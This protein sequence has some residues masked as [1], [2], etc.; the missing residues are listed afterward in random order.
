[1]EC[2]SG[3]HSVVWH[4][5]RLVGGQAT[6]SCLFWGLNRILTAHRNRQGSDLARPNLHD[7]RGTLGIDCVKSTK[8]AGRGTTE[9]GSFAC[10]YVLWQL[11]CCLLCVRLTGSWACGCRP[12]EPDGKPGPHRCEMTHPTSCFE[13]LSTGPSNRSAYRRQ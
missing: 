3:I 4:S 13:H 11:D 10:T 6:F 7:L 5:R 12:K 9:I 8:V 2:G 1:M